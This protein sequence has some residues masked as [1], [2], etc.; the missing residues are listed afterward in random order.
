MRVLEQTLEPGYFYR[1]SE[2]A[3]VGV[4]F[5]YWSEVHRL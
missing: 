5:V 4:R 2:K 3:S 1:V